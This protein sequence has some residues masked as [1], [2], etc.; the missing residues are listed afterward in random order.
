MSSKAG[1]HE[2]AAS[3]GSG[4]GAAGKGSVGAAVCKHWLMGSCNFGDLCR[5]SHNGRVNSAK[6]TS[7]A[8]AVCRNWPLGHCRF[9][10]SCHFAHTESVAKGSSK[11]KGRF[12]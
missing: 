9:G 5:F 3:G 7:G 6:R 4:K 8:A 10:E 12:L 2:H 1:R 11:G